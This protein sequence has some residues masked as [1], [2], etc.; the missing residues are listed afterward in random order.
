M[1]RPALIF[2]FGNVVAFFDWRLAA[3]T[4][5]RR[6]GMSA[7]VYLE[8]ARNRGLT[9]LSARYERGELSTEAFSEQ[10]RRLLAED[11]AHEEFAAAWVDIFSLNAP[12]A[13]LIADLKANGYSLVLGSNTNDLHATHFRREFAEVSRAVRPP[14]P[15]V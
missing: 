5:G 9:P 15:V 4:L 7:D 8:H 14:G 11:L 10:A 1:T 3:E 13:R 6:L 12:V 2:D